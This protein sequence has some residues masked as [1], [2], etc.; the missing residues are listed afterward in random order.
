MRSAVR[1]TLTL[2]SW[3]YPNFFILN[4][5]P[6]F[7]SQMFYSKFLRPHVFGGPP[8]ILWTPIYF[9]PKIFYSKIF[10]TTNFLRTPSKKV[11]KKSKQIWAQKI[12]GSIKN[13]GSK[14]LVSKIFWAHNKFGVKNILDS[15]KCWGLHNIWG[16][17]ILK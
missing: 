11:V 9:D 13:L 3:L 4:F 5:H 7:L 17:Q 14:K 8:N 6:K 1:L 2:H 10:L 12:F 15:K 16:Q